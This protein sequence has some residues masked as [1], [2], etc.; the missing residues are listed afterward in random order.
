MWHCS[1]STS[2][3]IS[4]RNTHLWSRLLSLTSQRRCTSMSYRD[5]HFLSQLLSLTW[6][7]LRGTF[8]SISSRNTLC[9]STL[10]SHNSTKAFNESWQYTVWESALPSHNSTKVCVD[11]L[12]LTT[13]Q[14]CALMFY[15]QNWSSHDMLKV[16]FE[17]ATCYPKLCESFTLPKITANKL[18]QSLRP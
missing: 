2:C 11:V 10:I 13:Q 1:R 4:Y 5:I 18:A 6:H 12:S 15:Q 8:C 14:R 3:S 9:V 7:Y 16:P 17:K